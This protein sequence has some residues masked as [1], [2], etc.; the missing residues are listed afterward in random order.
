[1]AQPVWKSWFRRRSAVPTEQGL[2]EPDGVTIIVDPATGIISANNGGIGGFPKVVAAINLTGLTTSQSIE[3]LPD[4][5]PTGD[6]FLAD[7]VSVTTPDPSATMLINMT[8]ADDSGLV[9]TTNASP[10]AL[11]GGSS[12]VGGPGVQGPG[13][14]YT[15]PTNIHAVTGTPITYLID[16]ENPGTAVYSLH[17][18]LTRL[19]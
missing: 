7:Y 1:M 19:Q 8:F 15:Y 11:T 17:L 6:Y 18:T 10:G 9:E 2:V 14:T 12:N 3:I 13:T 4:S 5:L 16:V